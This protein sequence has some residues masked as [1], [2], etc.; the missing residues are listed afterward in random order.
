VIDCV[1]YYTTARDSVERLSRIAPD[2]LLVDREQF[3]HSSESVSREM[4]RGVSI[5]RL[6][7]AQEIIER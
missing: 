1:L 7:V 6:R 4:V 5:D 3:S 2:S